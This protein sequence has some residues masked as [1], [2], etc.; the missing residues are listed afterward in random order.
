LLPNTIIIDP[1]NG[2]P[3]PNNRI[4]KNRIDPNAETF[5]SFTPAP[6]GTGSNALGANNF[7]TSSFGTP[8]NENQ[9]V[10]R[11]DYNLSSRDAL[12]ARYMYD[13]LTT[14]NEPEIFGNDENINTGKGQNQVISWTHTFSPAFASNV[15]LGWNRFFE[16]QVFG[17]TNNEKYNVAC[18]LMQLP[19]VSC[20]PFDYGPPD[21]Q[22]GYS[23]FTVRDNGPRDRMNQRWSVDEK[24]SVQIGRHL[25]DF[26]GSAYRLNWTFNEVVFPR[27]VYGFDGVQTAPIGTVPTA[28]NQFADFLLGLAHS[29]TLSPTPFNVRE[30]SWNTNL[31]FQDN[32][33]LTHTLTLNLGLRWDLFMRPLQREG[34]I[35]NY[36]MNNNGGRIRIGTFIKHCSLPDFM[37]RLAMRELRSSQPSLSSPSIGR[38]PMPL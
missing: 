20:D 4:P 2:Q 3:F 21:I 17:T 23:V 16:H 18:G 19:H 29:L 12:S 38:E 26:G 15:L 30:N 5:M 6:N 31:Y 24:N 28:A 9:F 13:R 11:V 34:T 7:L 8:T 33:R 36:F 27:G 32:W 35:A 10:V 14:P 1:S 22:A 37:R 25:L